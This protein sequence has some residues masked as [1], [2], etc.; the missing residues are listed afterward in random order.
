[1][2]KIRF[3]F[4]PKDFQAGA[5]AVQKNDP[6]GRRRKYLCGISS[7][8]QVDAHGERMTK[9]AIN[10][11]MRQ[12]NEGHILLFAD[13]H[14]VNAT[15]DIGILTK[16]EIQ[17]NGDWNTEYRLYDEMDGVDT[18]S[19]ER[20]NKLWMQVNGEGPYA[21]RPLEKG[22]SIEGTAEDPDILQDESG[23]RALNDVLLDG[24]VVVPRPAYKPSVVNAV[25][26]ALGMAGPIQ[27]RTRIQDLMRHEVDEETFYRKRYQIDDALQRVVSEILNTNEGDPNEARDQLSVVFAEYGEI[28]IDLIVS[29]PDAIMEHGTPVVRDKA[30]EMLNVS[31]AIATSLNQLAGRL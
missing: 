20:A 15:D 13:T 10:S 24:V 18:M 31:K 8:L 9:N 3:L 19:V 27:L 30:T 21:G 25:S 5:H 16:A 7:G 2:S 26:K 22:F 17:D 4:E 29:M 6:E 12:A 28:M 23:R 1:M 14:G 11:F